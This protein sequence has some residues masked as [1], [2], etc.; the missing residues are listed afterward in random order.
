MERDILFR[1]VLVTSE[2]EVS[3]QLPMLQFELSAIDV[4]KYQGLI[5]AQSKTNKDPNDLTNKIFFGHM[6]TELKSGKLKATDKEYLKN[7]WLDVYHQ[8]VLP[9]LGIKK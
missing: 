1:E 5:R 2:N 9:L 7:Q 4:D 8:V 3:D 6:H